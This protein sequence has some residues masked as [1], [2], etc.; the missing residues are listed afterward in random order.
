MVFA[1]FRVALCCALAGSMAVAPVF[2]ESS[3][4][5]PAGGKYHECHGYVRHVSSENIRVHC[6]DGVPSDPSFLYIPHYTHLPGGKSIQTRDLQPNTPVHVYYT[7][8]L[9][10]KKAYKIFVADPYGHGEYGFKN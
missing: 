3:N 7:Q 2:A 5:M 1:S 10:I 8:S 9:G 4:V 6:I